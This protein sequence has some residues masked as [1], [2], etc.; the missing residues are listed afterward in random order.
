MRKAFSIGFVLIICCQFSKEAFFLSW[1]HFNRAS[2]IEQ[3][4]I[5]IDLPELDCHGQCKMESVM[6]AYIAQ[7]PGKDQIQAPKSL[8]NLKVLNNPFFWQGFSFLKNEP[9]LTDQ[10]IK[11]RPSSFKHEVFRPPTLL[12]IEGVS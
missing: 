2:F 12:Q 7:A 11:P 10:L 4:C 5:N 9:L 1:Y 3:Y 8:S 6:D